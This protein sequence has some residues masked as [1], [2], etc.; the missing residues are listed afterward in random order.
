MI[1]QLPCGTTLGGTIFGTHAFK[2]CITE[3]GNLVLVQADGET[4]SSRISLSVSHMPRGG[5]DSSF[6]RQS[7]ESGGTRDENR[8]VVFDTRCWA[9]GGGKNGFGC[10]LS[11]SKE[12]AKSSDG[13]K[14]SLLLATFS[15]TRFLS[16]P[17]SGGRYV[18]QLAPGTGHQHKHSMIRATYVKRG[19]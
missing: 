5:G 13:T 18:I 7:S 2:A 4:S 9:D 8:S 11:V 6:R 3:G 16:W 19:H 14:L 17:I 12:R 10:R 1:S 15:S